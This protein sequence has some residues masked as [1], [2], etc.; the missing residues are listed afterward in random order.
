MKNLN[1]RH[2]LLGGLAA[3]AV[4]PMPFLSRAARAEESQDADRLFAELDEKI[5][6][7][8]EDF[9]IPGCAVSVVYRGREHVRG[10]GVANITQPAPVDAATVFRLASNSKT[11]T[12]AAAMRLVE[13]GRLELD[14][15]VRSYLEDFVAAGAQDVRVRQV[16]NHSSGWLGYDY[17]STGS[18][19]G[20]L[21]RYV[22]DV[23]KLPQLTPVGTTFSYNNAALSVAGRVVEVLTGGSYESSIQN[24]LFEPLGLQRSLFSEDAPDI[25][26]VAMPHDFQDGKAVLASEMFHLPRSNN[27]FAGVLSCAQDQFTY[28]RFLLGDGRAADGRRVMSETALQA[29][30]WCS[31]GATFQASI[32][33][34]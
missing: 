3:S 1:R 2:V 13:S 18:D 10:F 29:S 23:R 19:P 11:Y 6:K 25:G 21:A 8:M 27:P 22:E 34:S 9:S 20:A 16:L 31:T 17:H 4:L 12:G 30:G 5:L 15:P 14:R 24:L 33:D 26:N 28:L 32:P 7:G